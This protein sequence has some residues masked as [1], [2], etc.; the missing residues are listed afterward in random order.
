MLTTPEKR[1]GKQ[2]PEMKK[3]TYKDKKNRVEG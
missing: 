1:Q 3:T 2:K